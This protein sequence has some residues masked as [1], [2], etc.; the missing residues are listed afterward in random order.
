MKKEIISKLH[1]SFELASN[2]AEEVEFW[3]AR[4]LQVLLGYTHWRNFSLV[5][6]KAKIACSNAKQ[7][8]LDHFADVSKMVD[9]GSGAKRE[10]DDIMFNR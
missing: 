5:I 10:V 9:L 4:D 7:E 8:V 1:S 2:Q 3:F 6:D